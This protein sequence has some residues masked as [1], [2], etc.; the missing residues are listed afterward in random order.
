MGLSHL[1]GG[2]SLERSS[3]SRYTVLL[4]AIILES[5]SQGSRVNR[6]RS[7]PGG[8]R[9]PHR[10][11][12]ARRDIRIPAVGRRVRIPIATTYI[13]AVEPEPDNS[14]VPRILQVYH[15]GSGASRLGDQIDVFYAAGRPMRDRRRVAKI[16]LGE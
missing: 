4:H 3:S 8:Y 2:K 10:P 9:A 1:A 14:N 12:R 15:E 16:E 6:S 5:N 7:Y 11:R 13:R